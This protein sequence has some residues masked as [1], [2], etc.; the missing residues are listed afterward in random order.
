[1]EPEPP[2]EQAILANMSIQLT[3]NRVMCFFIIYLRVCAGCDFL[4][5]FGIYISAPAGLRRLTIS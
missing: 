5:T 1:M 4:S 3:V 2:K